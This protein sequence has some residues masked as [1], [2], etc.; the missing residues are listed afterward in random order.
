MT[1]E[2]EVGSDFHFAD[3][4][5]AQFGMPVTNDQVYLP[6]ALGNGYIQEIALRN[7]FG[8]CIHQY[9]LK[10]ALVLKRKAGESAE[11]LTV[12]FDGRRLPLNSNVVTS[13]SLF[14]NTS[15]CEVEFGTAN[16]FSELTVPPGQPILFIVMGTTREALLNALNLGPEQVPMARML[17]TNQ[18]FMLHERLSP[19][20]E[21]ALKQLSQITPTAP[22][23]HLLYETK[24]Q[25]LIYLLFLKLLARQAGEAVRVNPADVATLYSVRAAILNDLS[26]VPELPRLAA[27]ACMSQS[28][29]KQLFSQIFGQSIYNYY[30][31]ER[32]EKAAFL[33]QYFSVSETGYKV[34]FT[35]LSHFTQLFE[36]HHHIKPKK[37]KDSLHVSGKLVEKLYS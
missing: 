36:K 18:S 5:G 4:F 2:F 10:Q 26:I 16:F 9:S 13:E 32:M 11:Q 22:L 14:T 35:N 28:K 33:L 7:G 31:A 21:R 34:G 24:T 8:L 30:Q 19:E 20:M 25:E 1:F 12:K 23:A 15:G 6:Q 29:L 37:Y 27:D 17:R 3:A